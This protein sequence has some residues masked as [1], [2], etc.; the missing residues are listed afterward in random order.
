MGRCAY[1]AKATVE[2]YRSIDALRWNRLGY[3][4][5]SR[6]FSWAWPIDGERVASINVETQRPSVTLKYRFPG[7][8]L[9]WRFMRQGAFLPQGGANVWGIFTHSLSD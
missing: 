9:V 5:S 4:Q 8:R 7:K 3:F 6:W 1:G 2:S